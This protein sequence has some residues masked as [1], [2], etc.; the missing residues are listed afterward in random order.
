MT[1]FTGRIE[2]ND[3][4]TTTFR[5]RDGRILARGKVIPLNAAA[6][7]QDRKRAERGE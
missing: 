7:E 4:G 3:D 6:R 2:H 5:E 1:I